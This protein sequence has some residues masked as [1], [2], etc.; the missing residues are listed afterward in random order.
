MQSGAVTSESLRRLKT[1]PTIIQDLPEKQEM[2]VY[3]P[4]TREQ[5][6]LYEEVV[7][8]YREEDDDGELQLELAE[9]G[10]ARL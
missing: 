2:K 5:A 8:A 4:L 1:D 6:T 7:R 9:F 3:C 10:D